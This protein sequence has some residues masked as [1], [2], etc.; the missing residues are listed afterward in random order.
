M[1]HPIIVNTEETLSDKGAQICNGRVVKEGTLLYS[2]KLSIGK[3][4]FACTDLFTNEAIAGLTPKDDG[5]SGYFEKR[6]VQ[7]FMMFW[8][9][10]RGVPGSRCRGSA[11]LRTR[12]R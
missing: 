9:L 3:V 8:F 7:G 12:G 5:A 6:G 1:N 10:W 2:F 11:G 4:A